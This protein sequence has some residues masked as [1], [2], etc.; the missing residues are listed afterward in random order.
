MCQPCISAM[1]NRVCMAQ[2]SSD[3]L[4]TND[5]SAEVADKG[6]DMAGHKQGTKSWTVEGPTGW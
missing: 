6:N 3:D 4:A 2:A 5:R 1:R